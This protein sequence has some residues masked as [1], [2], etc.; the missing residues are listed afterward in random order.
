MLIHT[1]CGGVVEIDNAGNG[2]CAKC[3]KVVNVRLS[4]K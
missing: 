4:K 1:Q 2:K 3:G